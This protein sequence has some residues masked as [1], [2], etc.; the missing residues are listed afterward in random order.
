MLRY[1]LVSEMD[2]AK[3]FCRVKFLDD[4]IVSPP[5]QIAFASTQGT[6]FFMPFEVNTC[7]ACVM[8]KHGDNGVVI[9]AVYQD[10]DTP[11]GDVSADA[12]RIVFADGAIFEY[13]FNAKKF[14]FNGADSEILVTCKKAEVTA[15]SGVKITG[16][17]EITGDLKV[18]GKADVTSD[19]KAGVGPLAISLMT[20]THLS[21]APGSPT[22]TPLP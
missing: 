17:V 18:G 21:A 3:G 2:T 1:G 10:E 13:D 11:D 22:G 8:D 7:V 20:H 15:S 5:M 6:K 9:G 16:D 14:T 4:D 19:V 12:M